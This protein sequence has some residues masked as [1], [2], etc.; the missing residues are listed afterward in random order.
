[1]T[2]Y[3]AYI[4]PDGHINDGGQAL[5]YSYFKPAMDSI[6]RPSWFRRA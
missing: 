4:Q 6:V 3:P 2:N 1:M 5:W